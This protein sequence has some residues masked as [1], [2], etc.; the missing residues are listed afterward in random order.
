MSDVRPTRAQLEREVAELRRQLAGADG[1]PA[2]DG[3]SPSPFMESLAQIDQAMR[4]ADNVEDAMGDVLEAVLSV[5]SCDRAR[6][7]Y[8]CDPDSPTWRSPVQRSRPEYPSRLSTTEEFPLLPRQADGFRVALA[9]A[10]PLT[11]VVRPGEPNW[12]PNDLFGVRS[13]MFMVLR[14]KTRKPWVFG[15]HQCS[16]A[17]VW[18]PR[19]KQLFQEIG[20]RITDT[21][22][23]LLFMQ[24]LRQSQERYKN[25]FDNALVGIFRSRLSDGLFLEM[26]AKA[27][28]MLDLPLAEI[29][30]KLKS[31][32][33]YR[34][35]S[36][37][38]EHIAGLE[39]D[40]EVHGFEADLTRHDGT[41]ITLSI[42]TKAYPDENYM[43]GAVIDVTD[44][45]QAEAD[46][47]REKL[48]SEEYI[49]SLPGLFYVF[50][51]T[52]FVKWNKV[53]DSVTGYSDEELSGKYGPDFFEGEDRALIA[54]RM[55][56]VF[57]DGAAVAEA[58]LVTK[59]GRRIPYY[60]TGLR[61][62]FDGKPHL[63]G[64]GL[65]IT[66]R[67]RAEEEKLA[68]ERQVQHAQKLESLGVLAGGIA[69]DFNNLLMAILGNAD[70]ALDG[71]SP[72]SPAR[73][74]IQEIERASKRAAEL[75]RQMLAYSGK[76]RFVVESID[77]RELLEEI[78]H[79]LEVSISK[80]TV[81]KFNFADNLPTF[82]GDV[83]QIRQVVMNMIT[84]AAEAIGDRS[85]VIALS[86]GA[87]EC[88]RAYLD[89]VDA[90]L[91]A[92][93]DEPLT[94]G[95]YTYF[96]VADTGCGM[97]SETVERVFDPFFTTKFTGRGLGMSA[98]LGIVRGHH[99]ALKVYS[100][101][102]RGT[103][104]KVLFPAKEPAADQIG[105]D[106]THGKA[107]TRA[108]S[109]VGTVLIA[110]DE[111]TVC[112]VGKQM[113][114]RMGFSVLTAP[115]GL[116]ALAIFKQHADEIACVLLDLTM[117]RMDGEEVFREMRRLCPD[118]RVILCSGYN[119]QDATQRFAGK[120]L[121]GFLQKPFT[122]SA[123]RKK[124]EGI[125]P[126]A[127]TGE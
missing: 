68:L 74:N 122:S 102:G 63:V 26:N 45:R 62:E 98:V 4:R 35:P 52:R 78:A 18:S 125:L 10:E 110:D 27:A 82:E 91:R 5:L 43:E 123:L 61:C 117:P 100:E 86:T 54:D 94:E 13:V 34:D 114:E 19:D 23:S 85:G 8:P 39:R 73:E 69:H 81:L 93:L 42:S 22:S 77:A 32:D 104:F 97:D 49:N 21:L 14:P 79:L 90:V 115:D 51:E 24:D 50:D 84:N 112:A 107:E 47:L 88:D 3:I 80:K 28:E 53:W 29:I 101:V 95:V 124:L 55:G 121:A 25:Y 108:W 6:L 56:A 37:R 106:R 36:Q 64:L 113:L 75:A 66:D 87:M 72:M 31:V 11:Q 89:E 17:R 9:A 70:L 33:L 20:R 99:G 92:G 120:G 60:F 44:R 1:R 71:L 58:D 67:R 57:R 109:G 116:E 12:E 41:S 65:D 2:D 83:T 111:E 40:G 48:L 59:D 38:A 7:V 103:T 126:G 96:E 15:V 118:V 76:G 105:T 119:K 30:G 46:L 16:R 127:D